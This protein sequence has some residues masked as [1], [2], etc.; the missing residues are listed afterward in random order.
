MTAAAAPLSS[1]PPAPLAAPVSVAPMM[2]RTDRH[3]RY[4]MRGITKRTLLYTEMVTTGAVLFGHR[5]KLLGFDSVEGPL[6]LQLGGDDPRALAECARIGE[7]WGY[8]E[9]NLNVGC[10]SDR[11]QNGNFGASLMARPE[12]VADAVAL[13][14]KAVTIPVTVKHRIGI[15]TLDSYDDMKR[16]VTTVADA[17]CTRFTVHAR[18]AWL[19]GLSPK[20]NRTVPPLRYPDVH[21]L[22]QELPHLTIEINGGITTLDGIALQLEQVDAVM[23]GRAAY[24]DPFLFSEVDSRFF[25]EAPAPV[26]RRA[27]VER[28]IPY[29]EARRAEGLPLTRIS[30]HL[31]N[32]FA[33]QHNGRLWRRALTENSSRPGAGVE[34]IQNAL[35]LIDQEKPGQDSNR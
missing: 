25:G 19:E 14:Q 18:K 21:R 22:K 11:V 3:F 17:G 10:P 12:V 8:D 33:G 35:T 29:I 20:E 16:F 31:L 26:N 23:L 7:G 6:A 30:R 9:V 34:V 5:E 4:F 32:A 24:D 15:D 27:A 13:M 2:K 1:P 28:M